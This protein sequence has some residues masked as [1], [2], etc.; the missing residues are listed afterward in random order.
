MY[1]SFV[2]VKLSFLS[3]LTLLTL[4]VAFGLAWGP[5]AVSAEVVR[6]L[7]SGIPLGLTAAA[8]QALQ[9]SDQAFPS[10]TAGFSAYYRVEENGANT[11]DKS[12]VDD[13]IFSPILSGDT[14]LRKAPA[15]LIE[16]GDNYTVASLSLHNI[17]QLTST[18]NLYYDDEGWIV[19]YLTSG[20]ES[21]QIW[22][23]KDLD[24]ESPEVSDISNTTLLEAINVAV[25]EALDETAIEDD[26]SDLGYYHWQH[27][28]ADNFL[29]MAVSKKDQGE[30][31]VQ[32][33][34]PATFTVAEVSATLWVSQGANPMAPCAKVTLDSS[35]LI[36]EHC[37][38][39]IYNGAANLEDFDDMTGHSWK[40]IHSERDAGGSGALLMI[41][42]SASSS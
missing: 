31:P 3:F 1:H 36:S 22:Q 34:V 33:S 42:Y 40:L 41:L 35:D 28:D 17:D 12:A 26:D 32:F 21:S 37:S 16:M 20:A 13:H 14:T 24:A 7:P 25:S 9:Q 39:G 18:V 2:A 11:L 29:M 27:T 15:T 19:A 5:V 6:E 23:A 8:R 30:Y 38:K 4:S 10:E